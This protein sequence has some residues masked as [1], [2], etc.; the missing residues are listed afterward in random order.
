[1]CFRI[2]SVHLRESCETYMTDVFKIIFVQFDGGVLKHDGKYKSL[3]MEG[4]EQQT[5]KIDGSTLNA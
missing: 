5:L 1:M 4:Y 2:M 3:G